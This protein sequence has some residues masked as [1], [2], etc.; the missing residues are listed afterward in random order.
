MIQVAPVIHCGGSGT[1]L[2]LF[3][4]RIMQV[5]EALKAA[6]EFQQYETV[7]TSV[8]QPQSA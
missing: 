5:F 3:P 2:W 8:N 1:R 6:I 7:S 4:P